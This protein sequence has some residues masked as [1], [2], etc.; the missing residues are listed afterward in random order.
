MTRKRHPPHIL[1]KGEYNPLLHQESDERL[2]EET[3]CSH[4]SEEFFDITT[5]EARTN[6]TTGFRTVELLLKTP[7]VTST[8]NSLGRLYNNTKAHTSGRIRASIDKV[9]TTLK[10]LCDDYLAPKVIYVITHPSPWMH[11]VDQ[12]TANKMESVQNLLPSIQEQN[13]KMNQYLDEHFMKPLYSVVDRALDN[14][15]TVVDRILPEESE[16][17]SSEKETEKYQLMRMKRIASRVKR[18]L[19]KRTLSPI[20]NMKEEGMQS[21]MLLDVLFS[22]KNQIKSQT[23]LLQS[24]TM[25]LSETMIYYLRSML[26]KQA[27][28]LQVTVGLFYS[29]SRTYLSKMPEMTR[30]TCYQS[31]TMLI[32]FLEKCRREFEKSLVQEATRVKRVTKLAEEGIIHLQ[33]LVSVWL[34]YITP[35]EVSTKEISPQNILFLQGSTTPVS[36]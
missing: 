13:A 7:I 21:L 19:Q 10:S 20:Q 1:E 18:R 12:Y 27:H 30:A 5:T 28:Q 11:Q 33:S 2:S 31:F 9:E 32:W 17:L 15:E 29:A 8:C 14:T 3:I 24:T 35:S 25:R 6:M 23:H 26:Q 36:T 4:P 34:K 22:A 16:D